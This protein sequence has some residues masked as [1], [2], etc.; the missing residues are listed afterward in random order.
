MFVDQYGE[1]VAMGQLRLDQLH[2]GLTSPELNLLAV[3]WL[4]PDRCST[5]SAEH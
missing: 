2:T 4:K 5:C 1:E 3:N